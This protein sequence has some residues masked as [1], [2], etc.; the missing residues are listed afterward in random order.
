MAKL[1]GRNWLT[2][3][4]VW[5]PYAIVDI[6]TGWAMCDGQ[7]GTPDY[8]NY[9]LIGAGDLYTPG[10]VLGTLIHNHPAFSED[11]QVTVDGPTDE[12]YDCLESGI[13]LTETPETAEHDTCTQGHY[14]DLYIETDGHNHNISITNQSL[15]PPCKAGCWVQKL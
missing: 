4:V 5:W 14:H 8:R 2:G 15:L 12:A 10:Q 7:N 1:L 13:K 9:L 3:L 11:E 6:P